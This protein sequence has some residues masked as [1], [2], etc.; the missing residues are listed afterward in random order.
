[1]TRPKIIRMCRGCGV[2]LLSAAGG[3]K[4]CG[5]CADKRIDAAV[6]E[7]KRKK[8]AK[9]FAAR[10]GILGPEV[11]GVATDSKTWHILSEDIRALCGKDAARWRP[12]GAIKTEAAKSDENLCAECAHKGGLRRKGE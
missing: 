5:P 9:A 3:K 12:L 8:A 2:Q 7:Q 4:D 11:Y 10:S 1:M 6:T